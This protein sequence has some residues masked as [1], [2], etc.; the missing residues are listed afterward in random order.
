MASP[1]DLMTKH[2]DLVREITTTGSHVIVLT[3]NQPYQRLCILYKKSGID[4]ASVHFIDAVT[5]FAGGEAVAG[6]PG[7]VFVNSP[8]DLTTLGIAFSETI[9]RLSGEKKCVLLDSVSV[10]LIY[11][12]TRDIT[13]FI[14]FISSK[15]RLSE[16]DGVYLCLEN[17]VDPVL[18]AQ[19]QSFVDN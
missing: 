4:L 9:K 12:S 17:G 16:S 10:M 7:V 19:L 2:V 14:H 8:G 5:K 3:A 13:K 1:S 18:L 11:S 6:T 15:L